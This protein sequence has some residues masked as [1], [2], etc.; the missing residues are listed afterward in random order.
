MDR[1]LLVK[2]GAMG[3]LGMALG[4]SVMGGKK[5]PDY[6]PIVR[7]KME[8][9]QYVSHYLEQELTE[10]VLLCNE[11]GNLNPKA[12]GWSRVPL[13]RANLSNHW[14]R[15]KKWNFWNW[16]S[17][18]FVFSVT[19]SDID[20]ASFCAAS[21]I[22]FASK[23][24]FSAISIKPGGI[25]AMPEEVEKSAGFESGL[26]KYSFNHLGDHIQVNFQC[27]N[28]K[29][30]PASAEFIIH[31]PKGHET[32]NIVV[33][34]S[35]ERFQMNSKHNTLPVEGFV[36]I[37]EKKYLMNPEECNGVQDFGRGIWPYHSIWNWGVATGRQDG[38]MI[39]INLGAKWTTG[40]GSNE[41]GIC[42]NGR[43]YKVM[44]DLTWEYDPGDWMKAWKVRADY[45]KMID[46]TL[47]PFYQQKTKLSL[48]I[49]STGGVCCFGKWN[50]AIRMEDKVV[51]VND[52]IG[53]AEEFAHKW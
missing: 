17:P 25:L 35:S 39:G 43:L 31:K 37:G 47:T 44:E 22:D 53:W 41:N 26:M 12:I 19:L 1:R 33:P 15:K 34:W 48:G 38:N 45:S 40:T 21:F 2:S 4:R 28:M 9:G 29:G 6:M 14:G 23:E 49:M 32:L 50:G 11:K 46:L 24:N 3:A 13:V 16:I 27:Q 20:Y 10:P 36:K 18:D 42:F 7:A 8:S 5:L 30:K 52:L 51:K